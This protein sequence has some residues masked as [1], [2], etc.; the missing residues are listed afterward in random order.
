MAKITSTLKSLLAKHRT[1]YDQLVFVYPLLNKTRSSKD[2]STEAQ[3][4]DFDPKRDRMDLRDL[5]R[6]IQNLNPNPE[7]S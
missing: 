2:Y 5:L 3:G 6:A 1:D 7:N 4:F